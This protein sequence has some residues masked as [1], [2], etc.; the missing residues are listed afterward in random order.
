MPDISSLQGTG[1]DEGRSALEKKKNRVERGRETTKKMKGGK[2]TDLVSHLQ[3]QFL[4][5]F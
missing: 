2:N 3:R 4:L 1:L 5:C